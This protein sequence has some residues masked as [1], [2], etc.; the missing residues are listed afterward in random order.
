M[1][2]NLEI[3]EQKK[4]DAR[5]L[6]MDAEQ[7]R[8]E[9]KGQRPE[10]GVKRRMIIEKVKQEKRREDLSTQHGSRSHFTLDCSQVP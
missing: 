9:G 2:G 7:V 3:I 8:I 10:R 1:V 4:G 6:R 5:A